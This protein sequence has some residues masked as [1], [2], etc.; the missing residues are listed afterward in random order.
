[1]I[2][3]HEF[4]RY[5]SIGEVS[6]I[7]GVTRAQIRHWE[8]E[9]DHIRPQKNARG[10][11]RYTKATIEQLKLIHELLKVQGYTV[12]GAKQAIRE[13]RHIS[14]DRTEMIDKL[15]ELRGFLQKLLDGQG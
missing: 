13:R 11:R 14:K 8:M 4:K 3:D 10:D 6:A 9:F 1:M 5:Y 2:P 15:N 7:I 12:Q